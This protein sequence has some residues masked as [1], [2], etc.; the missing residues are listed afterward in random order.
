MPKVPVNI[1]ADGS[2]PDEVGDIVG[3]AL[4]EH[5]LEAMSPAL[6]T[7]TTGMGMHTI[8]IAYKGTLDLKE[9]YT[10]DDDPLTMYVAKEGEVTLEEISHETLSL[11][12]YKPF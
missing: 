10:Y 1:E 7:N 4:E 12:V 8:T 11:K 5:G 6:V 9:L 2:V 3:D